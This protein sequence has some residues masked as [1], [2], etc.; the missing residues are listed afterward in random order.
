MS[1]SLTEVINNAGYDPAHNIEDA[2]WFFAQYDDYD[3]LMSQAQELYDLYDDYKDYCE[4]A[5]NLGVEPD[6]FEEWRNNEAKK[7]N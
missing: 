2:Q 4:D 3:D 1:V 5:E 6:S 7:T